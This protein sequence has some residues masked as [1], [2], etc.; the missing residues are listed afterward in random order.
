MAR[1]YRFMRELAAHFH[2]APALHAWDCWNETRWCVHCEDWVC[3]CEESLAAYRRYLEAVY[4]DLETLGE[5]WGRRLASWEDVRPARADGMINPALL[6]FG[7]WQMERARSMAAWRYAALREG[8]PDHFISAHS[9]YPVTNNRRKDEEPPFARG[10]DFDLAKEVDGFGISR[11]PAWFGSEPADY[12]TA[13]EVARSTA[14]PQPFWMSELQGGAFNQGFTY[15]PEVSGALQQYWTWSAFARGAE[16]VIYWCWRDE[17][18][19]VESGGY[20]I[21]GQDG[22]AED[23]IAALH[24]TET[25]LIEHNEELDAYTPDPASVGVVFDS[26]SA[27]F[28]VTNREQNSEPATRSVYGTMLALERLRIP[29]DLLDGRELT[30]PDAVKFLV[31]PSALCLKPEAAN[32]IMEFLERGGWVFC[33][34]GT[35]MFTENGFFYDLAEMR[36]LV[37]N[38]GIEQVRRRGNHV[39]A[40]CSVPANTWAEHEALELRGALWSIALQPPANGRAVA[41]DDQGDALLIDVPAGT[42][43]LVMSGTSPAYAYVEERYAGFESLLQLLAAQAGALPDWALA[44]SGGLDNVF[45]RTGRAGSKR[46]FFLLNGGTDRTI[47]VRPGETG[48]NAVTDWESGEQLRPDRLGCVEVVVPGPGFRVLEWETAPTAGTEESV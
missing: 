2:D 41:H 6:D 25:L 32:A 36:P 18:W 45:V 33:E 16:G 7:R 44:A 22:M 39:K 1:S 4:G 8:D 46:L 5:A 24:L 20:G 21:A 11:F 19:G 37:G 9:A 28:A 34:A 38:L 10:N 30:I 17:I 12:G 13:V 47:R 31:L 35:G 3:Y 40:S 48:L 14:A 15:G 23:R 29:F 43:H 26:D 42:G 27:L